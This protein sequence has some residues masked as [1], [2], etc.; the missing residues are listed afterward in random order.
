MHGTED[1]LAAPEGSRLLYERV[2]SADK[3]LK[4]YEGLHH[5]ILNEPE[6]DQ[7]I[8]DIVDWLDA[9]IG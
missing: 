8:A 5:E 2:A 9:R 6:K 3:T 4:L 1:Q 7:V